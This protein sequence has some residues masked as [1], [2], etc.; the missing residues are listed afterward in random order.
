MRTR[1]LLIGNTIHW[2]NLSEE[3]VEG[4]LIKERTFQQ[5]I[6]DNNKRRIE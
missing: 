6:R 5:E 2:G 3:V 1:K 4:K